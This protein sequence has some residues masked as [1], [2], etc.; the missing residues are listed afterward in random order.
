MINKHLNLKKIK[1][2]I[3]EASGSMSLV[4]ELVRDLHVINT[5]FKFEGKIQNII[6]FTR[7]H[8]DDADNAD[9]DAANGTKTMSLPSGVGDIIIQHDN[10]YKLCLWMLEEHSCLY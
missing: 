2:K 1:T 10:I 9:D 8:I 3:L 6:A 4:F 7:N 5:W